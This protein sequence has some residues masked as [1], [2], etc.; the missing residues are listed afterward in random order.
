VHADASAAFQA[1]N[2]AFASARLRRWDDLLVSI[3]RAAAERDERAAA[4]AGSER[5]RGEGRGR[6]RALTPLTLAEVR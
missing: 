1:R 5:A 6:R 2:D 4:F 3:A